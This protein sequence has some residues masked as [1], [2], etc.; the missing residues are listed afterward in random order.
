M[1]KCFKGCSKPFSKLW[2][3]FKLTMFFFLKGHAIWE[4]I[5]VIFN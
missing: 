3:L 1:E 5:E 4:I 2:L